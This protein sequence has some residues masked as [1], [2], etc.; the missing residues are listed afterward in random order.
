MIEPP[1]IPVPDAWKIV[2]GRPPFSLA[3][4]L[5]VIDGEHITLLVAKNSG[6][7]DTGAK[8][9]AARVR[10]IPVYMID[11]PHKPDTATASEPEAVLRFFASLLWA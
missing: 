9:E 7:E 10:G 5:A 3:D 11:R 1:A 6:G 2:L 4:E 8:L